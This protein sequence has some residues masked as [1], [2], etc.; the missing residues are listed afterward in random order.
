MLEV[1]AVPDLILWKLCEKLGS[2]PTATDCQLTVA[3]GMV[4]QVFGFVHDFKVTCRNLVVPLDFLL[5]LSSP[6][7]AIIGIQTL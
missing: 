3:D 2:A 1:G 7:D 6:F 4:A 5:V